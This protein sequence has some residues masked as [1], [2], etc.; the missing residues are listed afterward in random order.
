MKYTF[1]FLQIVNWL[2]ICKDTLR[3]ITVEDIKQQSNKQQLIAKLKLQK[4][5]LLIVKD[6]LDRKVK[7][8]GINAAF[9]KNLK[10]IKKDYGVED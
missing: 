9:L 6:I 7:L 10:Q 4:Q 2:L 1:S 5:N 8:Q 3:K